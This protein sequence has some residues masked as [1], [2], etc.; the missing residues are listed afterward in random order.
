MESSEFKRFYEANFKRIYRFVAIR[1]GDRDLAEDLVSEIFVKALRAFGDYDETRSRSS[2]I[3]TIARNHLTN[4]YRTAG[5]TVTDEDIED[6][7]VADFGA[8]AARRYDVD[9]MLRMLSKLAD[10]KQKL[11]R[12]KYL[13]ELSYEE[14]EERLGKDR[15]TLKVATFRALAELRAAFKRVIG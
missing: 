1:I 13:E 12:M 7:P 9:T 10:E 3:Y 5:R 8:K 6:L 2:W 14:M 4:H 15:N 11:I